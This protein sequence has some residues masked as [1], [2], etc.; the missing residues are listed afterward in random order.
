MQ[1][2]KCH[3]N[4]VYLRL[5]CALQEITDAQNYTRKL[6]ILVSHY[7]NKTEVKER[8]Q[9]NVKLCTTLY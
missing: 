9:Q 6:V 4:I 5:L 1:Y 8:E 7:N 3:V 2:K